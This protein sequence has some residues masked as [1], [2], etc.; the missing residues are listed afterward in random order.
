LQYL[1]NHQW[2]V[3]TTTRTTSFTKEKEEFTI[4]QWK[5]AVGGWDNAP[6][7]LIAATINGAHGCIIVPY[8]HDESK[9]KKS[10]S[11]ICHK[12]R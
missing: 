6:P 8:I 7:I 3:K 5:V 10:T 11:G 1:L 12:M 4:Y 2:V 9:V